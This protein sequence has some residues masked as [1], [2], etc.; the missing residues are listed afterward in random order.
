MRNI[1]GG[2]AVVT[3]AASGIGRAIALALA[4]EGVHLF[5]RDIDAPARSRLSRPKP[6]PLA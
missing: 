2:R 3:G 1:R 5:L 4:R 6:A